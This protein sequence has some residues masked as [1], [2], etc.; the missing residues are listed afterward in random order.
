MTSHD[1]CIFALC[2][3][4]IAAVTS[5]WGQVTPTHSHVAYSN[6]HHRH[7]LDLYLPTNQCAPRPLVI[8]IHGGGWIS[9]DKDAVQPYVPALLSRGFAVASINYRFSYNAP[10]PAQIHDCKAAVRWL[11]ANAGQYG[12]DPARFG[13]LG[14]STGGHLAAL[15]GTSSDV[16]ALEGTVG[17]YLQHSSRVQAAG[18]MFGPS[19]FFALGTVPPHDHPD[20]IVSQLFGH[21]I[22]D[23]INNMDNPD[24][25]DLVALVHSANPATYATI[26][27]PPFRI[28]HGDADAVIPMNQSQL[29]HTALV[30]ANVQS[31]L[32]IVPG[33]RHS[34]PLSEYLPIFDAFA[35]I[36][37][38]PTPA[39][40]DCSGSVN[41]D[42]LLGV[43]S[44]WG[45][46][47]SGGPPC[48]ADVNGDGMVN[49][50]DLLAVLSAWG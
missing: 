24:Y 16:A 5:A 26:D 10:F 6:E 34:M 11:R 18:S 4:L 9:G 49:V 43:I 17:D 32:R 50:D 13:V 37:Q 20:S 25:A 12:I 23:I 36:L 41:V 21:P 48:V 46:C 14:D 38:P 1:C 2:L 29:L 39:D 45:V 19:D 40:I 8:F 27:D 42:D 22:Q 28:V 15:I 35:L 30:S 44:S 7:V 3:T 31:H 47:A 33:A